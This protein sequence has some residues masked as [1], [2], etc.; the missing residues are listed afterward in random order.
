[1]ARTE[2]PYIQSPE[3]ERKL[4]DAIRAEIE[5]ML[6]HKKSLRDFFILPNFG[7]D[8]A[9]FMKWANRS[10]VRFL[11]CKAFVGSRQGGIGFGNQRGEGT[12]VDLLLLK[13]SQLALS[14]QFCRWILVDGTRPIGSARF[15]I[16]SNTQ[17]R[18]ATMGGVR[19]GK[20]NN[21]RV[22]TLMADA[23]SWDELSQ[24]LESFLTL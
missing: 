11:E 9:V 23:I 8:F 22:K 4:Q 6:K 1:M 13:S 12:Q 18:N 3:P 10:T 19:R 7:L 20:Q 15:A 17:A 16:F 5:A 14:D 21:L 2:E 24:A